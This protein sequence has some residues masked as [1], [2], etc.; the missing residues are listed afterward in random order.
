[1]PF[2]RDIPRC[3]SLVLLAG[4]ILRVVFA[5]GY[6]GFDDMHYVSRAYEVSSGEISE[7]FLH[8]G[9][10]AGVVL[11]AGLLFRLF[12]VSVATAVAVPFVCSLLGLVVAF[13]AGRT[14]FDTRTGILAAALLAI[15]PLDIIFAAQL[16]PTSPVGL[17][18]GAACLLF[19]LGERQESRPILFAAGASFG[20]T[21]TFAETPIVLALAYVAY[22]L[23]VGGPH[24]R[25]LVA[26]AGFVSLAAVDLVFAA[27][28]TGD[29][30]SRLKSLFGAE[31]VRGLNADVA[32]SGWTAEW[33]LQP[34]LRV[35]TEQ[36]LGLFLVIGLAVA[37]VRVV[38]SESV[39]ERSLALTLLVVFFWNSYGT[40]S[41]FAYAP[42]AR[43]PRYHSVVQLPLVLLLACWLLRL[44]WRVRSAA[45]VLLIATS[46]ACVAVDGSRSRSDPFGRLVDVI[47]SERP[48]RV[49]V[50][51]RILE[52]FLFFHG[53]S[54]EMPVGVLRG[55]PAGW[56]LVL[57]GERGSRRPVGVPPKLTPGTVV[58]AQSPSLRRWLA[59]R[60][61][62]ELVQRLRPSDTIYRRLVASPGFR[63]LLGVARSEFRMRGLAK[64]AAADAG[65]LEVYA[66]RQ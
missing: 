12:G 60:T 7:E 58:V 35:V 31:T 33:L 15:F 52:P 22:A 62:L 59:Q 3:L 10:R 38:R 39:V 25:H 29:P 9:F 44:E 30:L 4:L 27:F 36:E 34:L 55:D 49:I 2:A 61:D 51:E 14:F 13:L 5:S 21:L 20:A 28:L 45:L 42:L 19:L 66:T 56:R 18:G 63:S 41:P 26:L 17:F 57:D 50:E 64:K 32:H 47:A 23:I 37:V 24:R 6:V 11:P 54:L 46:L 40:V 8:H 48:A 16:S 1:M 43:L 53:Y 65:M